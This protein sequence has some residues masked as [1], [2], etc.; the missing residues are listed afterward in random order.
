VPKNPAATNVGYVIEVT[1]DPAAGTWSAAPTV[2]VSETA[3]KLIVRDATPVP[4]AGKRFLR[5]KVHTLP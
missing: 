4:S 5:L 3:T 2:V 1:G